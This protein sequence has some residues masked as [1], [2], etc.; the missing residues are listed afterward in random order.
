[1]DRSLS[2]DLLGS[3]D[4]TSTQQYVFNSSVMHYMLEAFSNLVKRCCCET[5]VS[6]M[7]S[8]PQSHLAEGRFLNDL[9]NS[10]VLQAFLACKL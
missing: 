1:M 3:L 9:T 6:L 2:T 10:N 7:L 8:E 4:V 5:H